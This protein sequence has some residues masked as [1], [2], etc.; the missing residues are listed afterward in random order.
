MSKA[1]V[2]GRDNGKVKILSIG[3]A[4][5][6][7]E[8]TSATCAHVQGEQNNMHT[9]GRWDPLG[10]GVNGTKKEKRGIGPGNRWTHASML[11]R[12]VYGI[13]QMIAAGPT[14]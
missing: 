13:I 8:R 7:R 1:C 5:Q 10:T 6:T 3:C 11:W 4:R 9:T 14:S 2:R 12:L